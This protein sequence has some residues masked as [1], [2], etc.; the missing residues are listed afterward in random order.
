MRNQDRNLVAQLK[1]DL[2]TGRLGSRTDQIAAAEA[3][4][5]ANEAELAKA[6]WDLSQKTQVAPQAG[7]VY[8][9]LFYEG[10]WVPAGKPV[11]SL[12]PPANVKVRA[13]VPEAL[14]ADVQPGQE[15]RVSVDGVASPFRGKVTY[16]APQ[17][18][19]TPPV[20][21]SRESRTKLVLMIELRFDPQ[22]AAKLHP[23]QPVDV[24]LK[25]QP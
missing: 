21:Y 11:V 1:A 10:E 6:N 22:D 18:E 5:R 15:L 25:A 23:G 20:I 13:F 12:L 9:I 17:A 16:I 3:N 14:I 2:E 7:L 8:D 19:Y 4:V 24:Y